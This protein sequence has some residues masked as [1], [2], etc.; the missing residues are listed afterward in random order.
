M[1][2]SGFTLAE[3]LITLGV[4]GVVAALTLPTLM[5]DTTGAQVGPKLAK[6]VSMFEQANKALLNDNSVETLSD[7]GFNKTDVTDYIDALSNTFK[8]IPT[9]A[10]LPT[11]EGS[12]VL[13]EKMNADKCFQAKDGMVFC[14]IPTTDPSLDTSLPAYKQR[15]GAVYIDINGVSVPNRYATDVFAFTW[16]NDGSLRPVG[17]KAWNGST[18]DKTWQNGCNYVSDDPLLCAG[19]IFENDL[20]MNYR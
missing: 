13:T 14:V 3:V 5:P 8:I 18:D 6:A 12:T 2:K 20:K 15:I 11:N 9:T 1:K 4:I 19:H 7:G 17:S 10:V 16:W